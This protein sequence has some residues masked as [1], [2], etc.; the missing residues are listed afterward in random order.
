MSWKQVRK[1]K[2]S[3]MGRQVG[4]CLMNCRLGFGIEK[5]KYAS[6]K[7][8]ME[9][10]K[11]AKVFHAGFPTDK[12]IQV[13]VYCDTNSPYEH[14][15]VYDKGTVYSDGKKIKNPTKYYKI[16][17]WSE[18]CDGVRVVEKVVKK[19]DTEIAK[20]V[21]AGKWGNGLTRKQKLIKA[22]YDYNKVQKI[23]NILLK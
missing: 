22:G 5:G 15:V 16:F 14:I 3:K 13:P 12:S 8:A 23:V 4:W 19:S 18:F 2:L 10:D 11:K 21:I 17:G 7:S 20:E 1:F 6:A 9:A